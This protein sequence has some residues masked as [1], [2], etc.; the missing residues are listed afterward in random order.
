MPRRRPRP[1]PARAGVDA[2]RVVPR[3]AGRAFDAVRAARAPAEIDD[4]ALMA[5]FDGG[6]VVDR[7]GRA[8]AAD[9]T[10][11]ALL[12]LYLY[13]DLPLEVPVPFELEILHLDDDI[14][15][16]DKP[17]FLSTMPRGGHVTETALVRLRRLLDDDAVSPAHRLDRLTA[18]VLLFTLRPE[19]RG[20]Y[21]RL[22]AERRVHKVYR[23]VAP[24]PRVAMPVEI[25]DHIVKDATDLRAR[26]VAG[27]VNARSR[28]EVAGEASAEGLVDYRLTPI[29]GRT[30]QLRV[31]MAGLG[32]PIVG[33]PLY[34]E[35]DDDLAARPTRG[36]FSRPLRLVAAEL[37]FDDPL[38][39]RTRTFTTD[40]RP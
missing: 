18:G 12:P 19:V 27:E 6:E 39:G 3:T 21:Q 23:A 7:S 9:E 25:A 11:P 38:T 28:I 34:P 14:V 5:R 24:P 10:V 15:V 1:L 22:F 4:A 16:V 32:T 36:D 2:T 40:R 33:D 37:T 29:T 35:I 8:V 20:A 26:V 13:R 17:H 30:H 31:H